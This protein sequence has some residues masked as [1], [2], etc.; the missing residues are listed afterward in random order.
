[1]VLFLFFEQLQNIPE[2]RLRF[3]RII[4]KIKGTEGIK[5]AL[6]I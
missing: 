1:M 4:I 5:E 6:V 2:S 3:S